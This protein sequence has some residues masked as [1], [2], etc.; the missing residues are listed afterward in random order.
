M[1]AKLIIALTPMVLA[2]PLAM[3]IYVPAIP[4]LTRDFH[5]SDTQMLM[6]LNLF[7]LSAGFM[8]LVIG[9]ISDHFGRRKVSLA[10]ILCFAIGSIC[11]GLAENVYELI[12]YRIIQA[13][14]SC[15]MIVLGF[16]MVRDH[17]AGEK[18]AKA[19]SFLNG[20]ISFSPIFAT[21]IGSY[22]DLYLGWSATFWALLLVAI[23]ALYTI[24]IWLDESLPVTRRTP[25]TKKYLYN[26]S[27]SYEIRILLFILW[28]QRL[29]I[30][31]YI[32][33]VPCLLI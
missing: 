22:L 15:G 3:D 20:M 30:V 7:M 28:L 21:F 32:Y 29:V 12:G 24:G 17:Y 19:Y 18:S 13:L 25:L 2:L 27:T 11:C 8:Q 31:I 33:F 4:H 14:G 6:T 9:P 1:F 5:A 23:P 16:A 26:I 10:V